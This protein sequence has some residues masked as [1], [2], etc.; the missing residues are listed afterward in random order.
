MIIYLAAIVG[1]DHS[2]YEA[3]AIDGANRWQCIKRITLPLITPTICIMILLEVG[4][5]FCGDF[6]MVYALVKDSGQLLPKVDVIDTYVFRMLC[7]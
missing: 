2:L 6:G 5:I 7:V 1:I 4:K 3:A